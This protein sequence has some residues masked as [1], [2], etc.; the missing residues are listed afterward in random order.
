MKANLDYMSPCPCSLKTTEEE[1]KK[2]EEIGRGKREKG[3]EGG[4]KLSGQ[5]SRWLL[6]SERVAY[7]LSL[8]VPMPAPGGACR[9]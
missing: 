2:E 8:T 4:K 1:E 5:G 3:G 7:K 9:S 6:F